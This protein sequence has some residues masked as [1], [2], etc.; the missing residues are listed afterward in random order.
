MTKLETRISR[1]CNFRGIELYPWMKLTIHCIF[2]I[3]SNQIPMK[4]FTNLL[5][6]QPYKPFDRRYSILLF[7]NFTNFTNLANLTNLLFE[8]I[9]SV[10]E[11]FYKPFARWYSILHFTNLTNVTN[12]TNFL[13]EGIASS[14]LKTFY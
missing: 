2:F 6:F 10:L 13:L 3:F 4:P 1:R 14:F 11:T 12:L 8:V 5:A 9:T 7:T